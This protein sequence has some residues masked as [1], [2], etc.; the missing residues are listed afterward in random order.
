MRSWAECGVDTIHQDSQVSIQP[1]TLHDVS[2]DDPAPPPP[3]SSA[4]PPPPQVPPPH[5]PTP[6]ATGETQ[7]TGDIRKDNPIAVAALVVAALALVLAIVVIGGFI[8]VISIVMAGI[9]LRRAK[10]TG[11]GKGFA[12][13]ALL[14]SAFSIVVAAGAA[15]VIASTLRGEDVTRNGVISSS[16]NTEFPPQDDIVELSCTE[17]GGIPLAEI[18]IENLSPE[19][20]FYTLTITWDVETEEGTQ[21]ISEILR[22]TDGL[23]TGEQDQLRLFERIPGT[24][25]DS[26]AIERIERTSFR[27]Q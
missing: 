23:P 21:E 7:L 9:A 4:P 5:G 26:C 24:V 19:T 10:A 1:N 15:T 6:H 25:A 2:A 13:T 17:E 18:T 14:I 27:L 12:I 8:A 16:D 22:S 20:S 3:P 11:Q